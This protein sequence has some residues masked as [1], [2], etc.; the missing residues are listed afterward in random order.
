MRLL[1]TPIMKDK[2]SLDR[3][4]GGLL[5]MKYGS[6]IDGWFSGTPDER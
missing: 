6:F 2:E 5:A 3:F 4:F 1:E